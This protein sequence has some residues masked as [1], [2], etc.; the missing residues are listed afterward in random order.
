ML[1]L[2][3]QSGANFMLVTQSKLH[4]QIFNFPLLIND[5]FVN[6][7]QLFTVDLT[8]NIKQELAMI[9]VHTTQLISGSLINITE[10]N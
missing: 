9:S 6:I 1:L 8:Q 4:F 7:N 2:L 10:L 3:S 5:L